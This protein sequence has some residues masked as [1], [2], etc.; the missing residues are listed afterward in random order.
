MVTALKSI[1]NQR[2]GR[3]RNG[4][5]R[6]WEL[7][8]HLGAYS[9]ELRLRMRQV[10]PQARVCHARVNRGRQRQRFKSGL[11]G[12]RG[13]KAAF[14]IQRGAGARIVDGN[15][16]P[17]SEAPYGWRDTPKQPASSA[18]LPGMSAG[19]HCAATP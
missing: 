1:S 12:R 10:R 11:T 9:K 8:M 5:S 2:L 4:R 18:D 15:V 6:V 17:F 16:K 3:V 7:R 14:D 13:D 19:R